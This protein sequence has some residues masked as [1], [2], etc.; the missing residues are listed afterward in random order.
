[1]RLNGFTRNELM[2]LRVKAQRAG[3]LKGLNKVWAAAYRN[4][5]RGAEAIDKLME[6]EQKARAADSKKAADKAAKKLKGA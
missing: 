4:L 2:A 3:D 5:A 6:N 1:M